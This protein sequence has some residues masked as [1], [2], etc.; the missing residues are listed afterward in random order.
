MTEKPHIQ[1]ITIYTSNK[2]HQSNNSCSIN[3]IDRGNRFT[4][5]DTINLY[6]KIVNH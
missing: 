3:I 6:L 2:H 4:P 5:T 1:D